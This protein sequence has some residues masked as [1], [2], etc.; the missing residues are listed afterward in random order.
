MK[1]GPAGTGWGTGALGWY[2]GDIWVGGPGSVVRT[3]EGGAGSCPL[4]LFRTPSWVSKW[5]STEPLPPKQESALKA[6]GTEGLFLFSSLD[7]DRDMYISPEEFRPIAE[8]LTGTRRG[9]GLG[10]GHE[11][12]GP[13]LPDHRACSWQEGRLERAMRRREV[14]SQD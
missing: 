9:W 6:L 10:R 14:Q 5:C 13:Q 1:Q 2:R 7:A 4:C 8:K 12:H 3:Q 11:R